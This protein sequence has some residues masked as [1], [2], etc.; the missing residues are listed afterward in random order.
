MKAK[1]YIIMDKNEVVKMTKTPPVTK[2]GQRVF[3]IHI[4]IFDELFEMPQFVG[5]L[6]VKKED[7]DFIDKLEFEL[8]LLKKRGKN[9]VKG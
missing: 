9:N 8:K 6:E 1:I 7:I 2:P 3:D 5:K 4:D